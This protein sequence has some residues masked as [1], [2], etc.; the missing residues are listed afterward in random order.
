M[1]AGELLSASLEDYLEAIFHIVKQKGA[2]KVRDI[3]QRLD[4][5]NPSVTG[6]LQSLAKRELINYAPYDVITLTQEG[7]KAARDVIR[8]HEALRKFLVTVLAVDEAEADEN[9]C[10]MEHVISSTVLE[11]LIQF[12]KFVETCPVGGAKWLE[13]KGYFCKYKKGMFEE[14]ASCDEISRN[15]RVT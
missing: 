2:A 14:C 10:R 13:G 8:R 4:V 5:K 11:R 1:T 15:E 6:A 9:A 7:E 3:S 12:V